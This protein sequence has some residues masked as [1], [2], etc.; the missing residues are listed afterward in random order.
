MKSKILKLILV[1]LIL[2][3]MGFGG[4]SLAFRDK[5]FP[6]VY[7]FGINLGG[8]TRQGSTLENKRQTKFFQNRGFD[9]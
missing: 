5:I 7:A 9:S 1:I 6:N 8:M 3:L 2:A 4:Y